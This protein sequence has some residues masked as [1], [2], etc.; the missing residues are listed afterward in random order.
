MNSIFRE[1]KI[2][3][4]S[5]EKYQEG[6]LYFVNSTVSSLSHLAQTNWSIN[7]KIMFAVF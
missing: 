5:M 4:I 6:T 2:Q 3:I 7:F 1:K